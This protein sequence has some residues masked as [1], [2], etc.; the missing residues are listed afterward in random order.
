MILCRKLLDL[1]LTQILFSILRFRE[2]SRNFFS[3]ISRI[4]S[5]FKKPKFPKKKKKNLSKKDKFCC[6]KK[7]TCLW[8][9][10]TWRKYYNNKYD[11]ARLNLVVSNK[12]KKRKKNYT[13]KRAKKK[14]KTKQKRP[15]RK[16]TLRFG[17]FGC[18]RNVRRS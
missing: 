1:I 18:G 7:K 17:A 13:Q 14:K 10:K 3:K 4:S 11:S 9:C 15:P 12:R 8:Y 5:F 6:E 16:K 2:F